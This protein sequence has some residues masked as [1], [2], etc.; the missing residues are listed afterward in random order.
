MSYSVSVEFRFES[1]HSL[2]HLPIGHKCRN[3]HGHSYR[4]EVFCEGGLDD[5]GFVVDYAEIYAAISP[6]IDRWDHAYLAGPD[7]PYS[8][9]LE[10]AGSAVVHI[11]CPSSAEHLAR[12]VYE[13]AARSSIPVSKVV[14]YE[15]CT[16]TVTYTP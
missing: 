9:G 8:D 2:P 15:T 3:L 10:A 14:F 4:V 5:R 11:G 13:E 6:L 12:L 7:D 16:T 1:A